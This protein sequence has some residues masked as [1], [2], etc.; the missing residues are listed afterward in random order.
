MKRKLF[1]TSLVGIVI[2]AMGAGVLSRVVAQPSIVVNLEFEYL[3]Q[4]TAGVIS[5]TGPD[6][7]GAV[8]AALGRTY[9]FFH[10]SKGLA[11][12][13]AVPIQEKIAS[14]PI[15]VTV[16]KTDNTTVAWQGTLRVEAGEFVDEPAF[17]LPT[18][19]V[20]LLKPEIQSNEDERLLLIYSQVTPTRFW[21]GPFTRPVN[22]ALSSP[23]GS[24]RTYNDGSTRRHTGYDL[25]ASEG[26]PILASANGRVVFARALDIHGNSIIVDHG[27]GVFTEYSHLSEIYVV[28]GQFIMQGDV[29]GMSGNTGRSTGPHVHWEIAINGV[30]VN[31]LTFQTLKLPN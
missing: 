24:W 23:F 7:V 6:M 21:D 19:K 5:L 27:L 10:T 26:T 14:Y 12:L 9:P 20:Y 8:V 3:R 17:I 30:W 16:T 2:L 28:P 18:S 22:G 1:F 29:L 31:P 25:R 15:Q 4:G 13:L 11:C